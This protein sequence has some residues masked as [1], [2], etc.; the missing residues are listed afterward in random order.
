[1][2]AISTL[3]I[4]L[5]L[6]LKNVSNSSITWSLTDSTSESTSPQKSWLLY[7]T[8]FQIEMPSISCA[9]TLRVTEITHRNRTC[10]TL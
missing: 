4:F 8:S 1:M 7:I 5:V 10:R 6:L 2:Q 3:L 9:K